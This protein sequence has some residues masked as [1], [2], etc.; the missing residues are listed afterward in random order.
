MCKRI[1]AIILLITAVYAAGTAL[2]EDYK[3]F[4][5]CNPESHVNVRRSPKN[6]SEKTGWVMFADA[7]LTDGKTKNGYL[8]VI[9]ITEDGEGWIKAGYTVKDQPV[10]VKA[11]AAVSAS[12]RVMS[13]RN[14]GKNRIGWVPLLAEMKVYALSD[15]WAVTSR[16]YIRRKYLEVWFE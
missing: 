5:L 14:A 11:W 6:G 8:H 10:K 3:V 1:I 16:G 9:G 2:S 7:V 12:G 15:E 4:I 13:Y